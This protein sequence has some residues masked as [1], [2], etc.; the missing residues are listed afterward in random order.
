MNQLVA[1]G[2]SQLGDHE[3]FIEF[4]QRT[5]GFIKDLP[6]TE[7]L[8]PAYDH[9]IGL[10]A[11]TLKDI[12]KAKEW[13]AVFRRKAQEHHD[14]RALGEVYNHSASISSRQG[15][16]ASAIAHYQKANEHFNGIGDDKHSCRSM[17]S[18]AACYLQAGQ[19]AKAEEA[20]QESLE[21]AR[22]F[23]NK[24]DYALGYWF[25]AQILLCQGF[26]QDAASMFEKARELAED[27]PA[28]RGGWAFLGLG[29]VHFAQ[30][31]AGDITG[32]FQSTLENDPKM[33]FRNPYQAA[34]ILSKLERSYKDDG[35]FR[36]YVDQF[37]GQHPD[38]YNAPFSQWYLDTA[39]VISLEYPPLYHDDFSGNVADFWQLFDSC[40]DS[41]LSFNGGLTIQAANE[42]NLHHINRSAPRLLCREALTCDFVFQVICQP[43]AK[44]IPA[45]GGLLMWQDDKNWF[46]LEIGAH[47]PGQIIFRGYKDNHD[48]VFGR[49]LLDSDIALLRIE[50]RANQISAYCSREGD[51]W[52]FAGATDL[53]SNATVYAGI[54]ANGHINRMIYP[55]AFPEGS[56]VQFKEFRL[57]GS[58]K[59]KDVSSETVK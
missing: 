46:C 26:R 18:L 42:R 24:I 13:L 19:L 48:N 44:D 35:A 2:C 37:R 32:V 59:D 53:A 50:K 3:K 38:L 43:L 40:K 12:R 25:K 7:E 17:R 39:E 57:W 30:S 49:G 14:L 8:R 33:V 45:I 41:Q 31:N 29:Q 22:R 54:H 27:I 9:I 58:E 4:T 47:G 6:Y 36:A 52:F 11:Y 55:G 23:E 20:I 1:V 21:K 34:N 16:L 15:D 28:I 56:A 10:Y 51:E 5:A